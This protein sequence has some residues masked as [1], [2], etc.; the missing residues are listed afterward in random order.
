MYQFILLM[1]VECAFV[2]AL[3]ALTGCT[4]SEAMRSAAVVTSVS[5]AVFYARPALITVGRRLLTSASGGHR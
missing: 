2:L 1:L 4:Q 3:I 5:A